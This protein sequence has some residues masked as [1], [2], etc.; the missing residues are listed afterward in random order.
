MYSQLIREFI[1]QED[2]PESYAADAETWFV[3]LAEHFSASL[4]K[5]KRPL[6]VGITGAQGTGKSTLAKLISVLLTNDGFRVIKLSIDDFYLSRRARARLADTVHPLLASRGVPGTHDA[7][8]ALA[9]LEALESA[10]V[11]DQILL[12]AFSKA[13][14]DCIIQDYW[15]SISG[16][17]DIILLE[18]WF[19]GARSVSDAELLNPINELERTEDKEGGWR[20]YVNQQLSRDYQTIFSHINKLVMLQAP[21]FEKVFEWRSKQEEKLKNKVGNEAQGVMDSVE[22]HTFIQHYERLTRHCLASLPAHAD[23]LFRLDNNHR[24]IER[25]TTTATI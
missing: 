14:D 18:G 19:I 10:G 2:L 25:L 9:T 1:E 23:I 20:R 13:E 11:T 16:P 4:L 17:I 21:S 12:P 22:L 5:E 3:P 7:S 24:V 15:R 6:V 8:L